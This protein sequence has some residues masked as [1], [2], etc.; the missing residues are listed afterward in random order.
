MQVSTNLADNN[1]PQLCL[2]KAQISDFLTF[3]GTR[4]FIIAVSAQCSL[5][6]DAFTHEQR[7]VCVAVL[8]SE[9]L[10]K[11]AEYTLQRQAVIPSTT[12]G[13]IYYGIYLPVGWSLALVRPTI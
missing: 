13:E 6:P 2:P 11:P 1:T 3:W 12:Y 5:D 9:I 8:A 10:L 7:I 4:E